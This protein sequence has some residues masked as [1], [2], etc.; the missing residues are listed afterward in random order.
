MHALSMTPY[1]TPV[2]PPIEYFT[3]L[4]F[5]ESRQTPG[6]FWLNIAIF[7][8]NQHYR[9]YLNLIGK[10]RRE[11]E[12]RQQCCRNSTKIGERKRKRGRE[13]AE[14]FRQHCYRNSSA[15]NAAH[16]VKKK[17]IAAKPLPKKEK[18]KFVLAIVAM[19][20]PKMEKKNYEI[21]E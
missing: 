10:L 9:Y 6:V 14:E 17:A 4:D 11:K 1:R 19:R 21:C 8:L 3:K 18:K 2:T 7:N 20:L 12:F 13:K 15:Q 16:A 5:I